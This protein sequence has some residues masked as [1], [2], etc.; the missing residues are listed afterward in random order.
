[1]FRRV[2]DAHVRRDLPYKDNSDED[3]E[4]SLSGYQVCL[5]FCCW[6]ELATKA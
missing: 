4:E 1:M 2:S 6:H 5:A 3:E